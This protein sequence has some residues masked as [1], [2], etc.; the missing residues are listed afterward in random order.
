MQR[1]P[2][3]HQSHGNA[4]D[5]HSVHELYVLQSKNVKFVDTNSGPS[6]LRT[7]SSDV[8]WSGG[9]AD[10]VR[11]GERRDEA[12]EWVRR[13]NEGLNSFIFEGKE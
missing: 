12:D 1:W 13:G 10:R 9:K 8:K 7:Q 3:T 2:S 4:E 6:F 11:R 5:T